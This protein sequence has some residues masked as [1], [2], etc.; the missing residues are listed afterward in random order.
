ME[1]NKP[2]KTTPNFQSISIVILIIVSIWFFS[3]HSSLQNKIDSQ[4]A[5]ID[6][7]N[8]QISNLQKEITDNPPTQAVALPKPVG[9]ETYSGL[10][11][12]SG[13]IWSGKV[14]KLAWIG[15]GFANTNSEFLYPADN[16]LIHS[17]SMGQS[18]QNMS[19]SCK[20]GYDIISAHSMTSNKLIISLTEVSTVIEDQPVNNVVITCEKQ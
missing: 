11:A 19:V 17:F 15:A 3:D 1:N 13:G 7:Q 10:V 9:P 5:Q 2:T 16:Y 14:N 20:D 4:S 6:S 18:W 8:I 12:Q